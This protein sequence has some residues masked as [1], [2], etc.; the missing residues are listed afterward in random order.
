MI[1]V[2]KENTT[3]QDIDTLIAILASMSLQGIST[4]EKNR[5]YIA[6]VNGVTS[7]TDLNQLSTL[8]SVERVVPFTQKYKLASRELKKEPTIITIGGRTVIGSGTVAIIAG[9]CSVES[10]EQIFQT[11][12]RVA[13]CGATIL[14]G[15]A[16]KPR[17]SPY[18][19]QGLGETGLNYMQRAAKQHNLLSVSEVMDTQ[20]IDLIANYVDILQIGARNMQNF[21]LLKQVGKAGKPIL[22]KRGLS[23]TYTEFLM[24]AEYILQTGNPNVILCE[25]GIRTFE[26]HTRNTLDIAAIPIL[27][28]LSHLP[29]I[30]DPSHGTGIRSLVPAM[31]YAAIAAGADGIMVEV[32]PTPDIAI[33][34]A[35][36]TISPE[37]FAEMMNVLRL[38]G[39]AVNIYIK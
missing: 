29:V 32:H 15:G 8:P 21:S 33:S 14:R 4:E 3:Q 12:E 11:A 20:D 31:A 35:Q 13:S 5:H 19:F 34:D 17:T 7:C 2:M 6:I 39:N 30:V 9:P 10:E 38:V 18:D 27:H 28:E 25:R 1:L 22:L 23:A 36:Q 37:T 26:P 24:A 16:F